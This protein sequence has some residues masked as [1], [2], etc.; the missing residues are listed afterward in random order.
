[1]EYIAP[2]PFPYAELF[3]KD[4]ALTCTNVAGNAAIAP[5]DARDTQAEKF[6]LEILT[7]TDPDSAAKAPPK[8]VA[9]HSWATIY[10]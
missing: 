5:P 3:R 7:V 4:E 6:A 2:P 9:E 10:I 8:C 1:M